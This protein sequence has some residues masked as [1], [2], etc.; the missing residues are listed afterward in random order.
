ME[1]FLKI[2]YWL[3]VPAIISLFFL[4]SCSDDPTSIGNKLI[5]GK[6]RL[7]TEVIDSKTGAFDQS[8]TSF[9]KDSLYYGSSN[10]L[11][12]GKYE[13][14]SSEALIS[15][16]I[17]LPDSTK[18][19]LENSEINLISSWI[20]IY[21][22]YWIG[23]SSNFS[24]TA[25]KINIPW[26]SIEVN[27]DTVNEI[28]SSIGP[29]I[30]DSFDYTAGDTVIKF[31]LPDDL[32]NDWVGRAY[33]D[34]FPENYGV[35]LAPNT[36]NGIVGFQGLA[37]FPS[38]L[39]PKLFL[40]FEKPGEFIDTVLSNPKLDIHLPVGDRLIEPSNEIILQSSIN[41]RGKLKFDLST[42]PT[43]VIV[44]S[45]LLEFFIDEPFSFE[46]TVKSDTIAVSF[47]QNASTD[48]ITTSFGRY[49]ITKSD[50]KYSG[51]IRQFVQ[52]WL[53][54]EPNEGLE[55]KLSDESRSASAIY[56]YS[57]THPDESLRPRLTIYYSIK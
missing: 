36:G 54:G 14:I 51:E 25:H 13:N 23:D 3:I 53:D 39:F 50:D 26:N 8:F 48:S 38:Y 9:Q 56:L 32:M 22:N 34:S 42:V 47:F 12:L 57:S 31:S 44:N 45:A 19:Q 43:D 55:V 2:K 21:P 24:F 35:L 27:E 37:N 29:D 16:L 49:P 17:L 11:L 41:V 18:E 10:R 7:N 28:H 30:I 40:L 5:P 1:K 20:E 15:F 52:R 33:D 4:I 6:D 46:G